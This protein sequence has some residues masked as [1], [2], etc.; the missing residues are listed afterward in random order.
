MR[1]NYFSGSGLGPL[2]RSV[3]QPVPSLKNLVF[4]KNH[5]FTLVYNRG[6]TKTCIKPA[7]FLH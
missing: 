7:P 2:L 6:P 3:P 5:L 4:N 1:P